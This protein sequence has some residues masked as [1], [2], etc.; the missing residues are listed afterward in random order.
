M[1]ELK[2]YIDDLFAHQQLNTKVKD[3][4]DE[5]YSNMLAKK[6][7]LISQGLSEDE[8]I[9][10]VKADIP[11]IDNIIEG[12]QITYINRFKTE[13][14]QTLLLAGVILW[15]LSM[16]TIILNEAFFSFLAFWVMIIFG[17]YYLVIKKNNQNEMVFINVDRY[18][19]IRKMAWLIWFIYFTVCI[20]TV[21]GII[22][23]SNIWFSRPVQISGPY[24]FAVIA[25]KYYIPV[26]T[27]LL[28]IAIG[29]FPKILARNERKDENE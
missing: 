29:S 13:C 18:K 27:V 19:K 11:T 22:F 17:I 4:K 24:Q 14:S 1:D 7:D 21:S 20:G 28:P 12:N 3:L 8:A 16:P 5:I 26:S 2:K 25:V 15:I 9:I 10:R 6:Q 23:G